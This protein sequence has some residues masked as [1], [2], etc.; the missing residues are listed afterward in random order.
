[1]KVLV[2]GS[3]LWLEQKAIE[4]ELRKLPPGILVHGGGK[5]ADNIAGYVGELLGWEV[6]VY[7][8][9]WNLYGRG[10]GPVRNQDMLKR[11]H[12]D[13]DGVYIDRLLAFYKRQHPAVGTRGMIELA[14]KAEPLIEIG[15]YHC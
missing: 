15:V 5:G 9:D 10:G 2:C 4:R 8:A 14:R 7:P 13:S 6:R 11:E 12:P 1:M 3:R